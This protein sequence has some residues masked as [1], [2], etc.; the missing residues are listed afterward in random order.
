MLFLLFGSAARA[1]KFNFSVKLEDFE[2]GEYD[3]LQAVVWHGRDTHMSFARLAAYCAPVLW[4]SPDEPLL[5]GRQGKAI[6][7]PAPFPFE[8]TDSIPVVYYRVRKI[9]VRKDAD[10]VAYFPDPDDRGR[11]EIDLKKVSGIDLDF[12]FYYPSES[13]LGVHRHDVES[14]QLQIVVPTREKCD[15]SLLVVSRVLGKAHGIQWYDNTLAV[16]EFTKF[17]IHIMSEEG[18]H[19]SCPDKNADGYFTPAYDVNRRVNDS[20]GVRDVISSGSLFTGGFQAWMAKVRRPEHRVFPPLPED[21]PLRARLSREGVYAPDNAIYELRPF[22]SAEKAEPD[23]VHFIADKGDP[24]W[25]AVESWRSVKQ[26]GEWVDRESFVKSLSVGF[27]ADGNYG[28]SFS[29][30]FFIVKNFEDPM[31]GGFITHRIIFTDEGLHDFTWMANYSA[32]ASRWID[33]YFAAG[34]EWDKEDA[35]PG[36]T[37]TDADVVIETGL[38]FRAS[39]THTPVKFMTKLADF[40]GV[41]FGVKNN[42]FFEI[43][44]LRYVIEIGAGT[45]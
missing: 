29:F 3:R 11:S 42:G 18:K 30:P 5:D 24:N 19:A 21:S 43:D 28:V 31:G 34:V 14:A 20:W 22:P 10:G 2:C 44:R 15:E 32:S 40:W 37:T 36:G 8:S 1:Q 45:W 25:P 38:K 12:F 23:L 26:F 9:L 27:Y 17:P 13:G 39:L 6:A 4:Y 16:D 7:I 41:R 35:E 33:P